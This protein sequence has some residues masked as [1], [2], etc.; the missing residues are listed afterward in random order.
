V[1]NAESFYC[2]MR[3]LRGEIDGFVLY[4]QIYIDVYTCTLCSIFIR[5]EYIYKNIREEKHENTENEGGSKN[6]NI[7]VNESDIALTAE[8][9][10]MCLIRIVSRKMFVRRIDYVKYIENKRFLVNEVFPY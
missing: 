4:G 6:E 1:T 8:V 7:D 2:R 5:N 10:A 9:Q 3:M